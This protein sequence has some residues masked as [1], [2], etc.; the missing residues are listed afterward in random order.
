M[1]ILIVF[2]TRPEAIKMASLYHELQK[3]GFIVKVC[4]TAQHREMLDQVLD[5][6]GIIP[7][8]DLDLM[9]PNQTLNDLSAR[10]LFKMDHVLCE[11]KPD[12]VLVH[13]DTTTSSMVALAAFHKGIKIGHVE[14]GLRTYNKHAPFPEEINRQIISRIADIH[15]TP[16]RHATQNLLKEGVS[17]NGIIET[18]NTVIDALFWTLNKIKKKNYKN[19]EIDELKNSIPLQKK[20]ILVTGHRREN[21]GEGFQDLCEALLAISQRKDVAI[22][23]PVHLNPNVKGV[24]FELL[25]S[26]KN[27]YLINPVSYPAFVWLMQQSFLIVS[28]SGGIQEEAPSLGKPVLVTRTVSERAEGI[29]AGFSTLVGT[30]KNKIITT[31]QD[32]LDNFT[33]FSKLQNPYGCGDASQ[34]IVNYLLNLD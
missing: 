27:I 33:G 23:F 18:G 16:T 7:D 14:A 30:D 2:G 25:S 8:Y 6:F 20:I 32:I 24:V 3:Q 9:Q 34:Q 5:F 10:I 21:F 17:G 29:A 28:D 12:L 26:K 15:F 11:V 4:V 13:G 19:N 22:V 1:K 31:I